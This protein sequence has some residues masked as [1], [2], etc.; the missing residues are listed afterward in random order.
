MEQI[1]VY[2]I[3]VRKTKGKRTRGRPR[4]RRKYNIKLELHANRM[5]SVD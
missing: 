1:S 2:K 4:H 5:R 3:L